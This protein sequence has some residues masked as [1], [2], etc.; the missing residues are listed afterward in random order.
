LIGTYKQGVAAGAI[1]SKAIPASR[2]KEAG[3]LFG[4]IIRELSGRLELIGTDM[5]VPFGASIGP[6]WPSDLH[7][8]NGTEEVVRWGSAP[9]L[10]RGARIVRTGPGSFHRRR[11]GRPTANQIPRMKF[12]TASPRGSTPRYSHLR[13]DELDELTSQKQS[14]WVWRDHAGEI[15]GRHRSTAQERARANAVKM[16]ETMSSSLRPS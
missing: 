14:R 6:T 15:Q 16:R 4:F 11:T 3:S 1:G 5:L 10:V 9:S 7:P 12:T 2:G 8:T 13:A